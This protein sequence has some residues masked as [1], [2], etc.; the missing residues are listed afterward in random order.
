MGNIIFFYFFVMVMAPIFSLDFGMG[1]FEEDRRT[2]LRERIL[3]FISVDTS[4]TFI[5]SQNP[6]QYPSSWPTTKPIASVERN[7]HQTTRTGW[8]II[9]FILFFTLLGLLLHY[10]YIHLP[11]LE[12]EKARRLASKQMN[13]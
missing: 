3:K 1:F 5:P 12:K 7:I 6:T 10:F 2:D 13:S 9:G 11:D 8:I 4:D